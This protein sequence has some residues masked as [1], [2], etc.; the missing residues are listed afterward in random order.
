VALYGTPQ[1]GKTTLALSLA[2]KMRYF[3][4]NL[5]DFY[6]QRGLS[7][8]TDEEKINALIDFFKSTK[9]MKIMLD[10]FPQNRRQ[11]NIFFTQYTEPVK[12]LYTSATQ[13]VVQ[14]R[15][16]SAFSTNTTQLTTKKK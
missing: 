3:Y 10:D 11:A 15:L 4:M 13:D 7:N 8:S 5:I 14:A 9:E 12:L 16:V 6:A 2:A 1:S